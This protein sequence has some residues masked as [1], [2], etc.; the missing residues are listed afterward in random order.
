MA[1]IRQVVLRHEI[2]FY[3]IPEIADEHI[4]EL[5]SRLSCHGLIEIKRGFE[6]EFVLVEQRTDELEGMD[7][8]QKFDLFRKSQPPIRSSEQRYGSL[9]SLSLVSWRGEKGSL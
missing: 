1:K 8:I 4:D 7:E 5:Q 2:A 6:K 9:V 3:F